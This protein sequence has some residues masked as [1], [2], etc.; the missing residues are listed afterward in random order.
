[1]FELAI[2]LGIAAVVAAVYAFVNAPTHLRIPLA[3]FNGIY[4]LTSVI[5]A[6]L[7][8]NPDFQF[9]WSVAAGGADVDWLLPGDSSRYWILLLAPFLLVNLVALKVQPWFRPLAVAV[10]RNMGM[11]VSLPAVALVGAV[12]ITYCVLNLAQHGYLGIGLLSADN[13]GF[14]RE[15]IQLRA[16]MAQELGAMHFGLVYMGLPAVCVTSLVR[17]VETRRA[18]WWGLFGLLSI[19]AVMMYMTTLTKSNLLIF[20]IAL[21]VAAYTLRMIR[22]RGIVVAAGLALLLLSVQEALLAG[23]GLL[24][25]A[26]TASNVVL[27]LSSAIPFYVEVLPQQEAFV[28]I[29]YGLGW[30]GIGPEVGPNIL[31]FN[32]M[33]PSITWVQGAAPAAAHISAYAQAGLWFSL[34][35]MV[36]VGVVIAFF[37]ALGKAARSALARS[38]FVGG[39]VLCYYATQ[40]DFVGTF[41]HSYG[42]KWWLLGLFAIS[43]VEFVLRWL[44]SVPRPSLVKQDSV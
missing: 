24:E 33:F 31:V 41:N 34:L 28:G 1:M 11:Q 13:V 32:Y 4:L 42:Y 16:A 35:T 15:N 36:L 38:A 43:G 3:V 22:V 30:F 5:G 17:A 19:G 27:R 9:L 18:S 25:F 39:G 6:I 26:A 8:T 12:M 10:S 29:D 37:G 21:G 7:V 2:T 20:I 23:G 14:Y 40:T 44:L